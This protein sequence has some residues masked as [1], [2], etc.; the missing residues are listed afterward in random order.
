MASFERR[1]NNYVDKEMVHCGH[2]EGVT[3]ARVA[4]DRLFTFME[5]EIEQLARKAGLE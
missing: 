4:R 3:L 2:E 5:K 1:L